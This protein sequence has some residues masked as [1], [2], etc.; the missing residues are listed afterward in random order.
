MMTK[1]E[2]ALPWGILDLVGCSL[3]Q[4]HVNKRIALGQARPIGPRERIMLLAHIPD[5]A[6][7]KAV[8][9]QKLTRVLAG[10]YDEQEVTAELGRLIAGKFI[11]R[12]PQDGFQ[13][14][15]G[16]M[17]LH[18][19]IVAL[20]L[21][22]AR[23]SDAVAQAVRHLSFADESYVGLPTDAAYHVLRSRQRLTFDENGIGLI[24]VRRDGCRVLLKSR[25]AGTDLDPLLQA[26]CVE[27][28]WRNRLRGS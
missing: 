7:G 9:K 23:V 28:F 26:H 8:T 21:K 15:N 22:L 11:S 14:A 24:A 25:P 12:T 10:L 27:R 20:E 19:R 1:R 18:R 16:W 4:R 17:P 5:V 6:E 2:F 13:K 3:N